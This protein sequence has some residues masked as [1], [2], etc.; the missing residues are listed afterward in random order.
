M[1]D[2]SK[3]CTVYLVSSTLHAQRPM[4]RYSSFITV[5]SLIN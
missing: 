5:L 2:I 4:R 1:T 3:M